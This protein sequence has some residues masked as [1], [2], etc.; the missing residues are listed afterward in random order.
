MTVVLLYP[1][2]YLM[3]HITYHDWWLIISCLLANGHTSPIMTGGL[4]YPVY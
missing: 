2:Y 1:V 3:T 4:L